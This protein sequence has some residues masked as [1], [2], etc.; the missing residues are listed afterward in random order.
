MCN[1]RGRL[2]IKVRVLLSLFPEANDLLPDRPK[3]LL[4]FLTFVLLQQGSVNVAYA[5][6][7]TFILLLIG[8]T[9]KDFPGGNKLKNRVLIVP[10]GAKSAIIC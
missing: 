1:K 9:V 2:A 3:A 8:T 4:K 7:K 5:L 10:K 6:S